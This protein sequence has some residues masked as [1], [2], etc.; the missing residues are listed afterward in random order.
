M[1]ID[2]DDILNSILESISDLHGIKADAIPN[3]DLYMDQVTTFMNSQLAGSRRHEN[4]KILTKTMI[5]NYAKNDLLPSPERK[6]YSK[7]HIMVLVFIYYFKNILSIKDI[8]SL[9][10]PLTEEY[11]G[12]PGGVTSIEEIYNTVLA[13]E[14]DE[15][16]SFVADTTEKYRRAASAFADV[17]DNRS[18]LQM[19]SFI[20]MMSYDVYVRKLVIEALIDSITAEN[21]SDDAEPD[22][23]DEPNKEKGRHKH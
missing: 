8:E 5:N 1:T 14:A 22:E 23:P 11:F 13:L 2:T 18:F 3:I 7:E 16:E 9:L 20:C 19:F 15:K 6:K 21:D 12:K 10:T 17:S 4:D